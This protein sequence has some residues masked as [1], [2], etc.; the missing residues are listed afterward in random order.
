MEEKMS[1]ELNWDKCI[2]FI[3]EEKLE[4]AHNIEKLIYDFE[5]Q[6]DFFHISNIDCDKTDG[7]FDI[8]ITVS[9]D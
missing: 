5:Q 4:L 7:G 1:E 3:T 2:D 9:M 8:R 6:S